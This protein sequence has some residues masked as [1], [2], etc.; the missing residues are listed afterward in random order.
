MFAEF[1][2][3]CCWQQF[4]TP[5]DPPTTSQKTSENAAFAEKISTNGIFSILR[6]ENRV[7]EGWGGT[8]QLWVGK[9]LPLIHPKLLKKISDRAHPLRRENDT[10]I[11]VIFGGSRA[12]SRVCLRNEAKNCLSDGSEISVAMGGPLKHPIFA[13]SKSWRVLI[14]IRGDINFQRFVKL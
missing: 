4:F 2:S 1:W 6:D 3:I 9:K 7:L 14:I 8:A 10:S 13:D 11:S 5:G 12:Q